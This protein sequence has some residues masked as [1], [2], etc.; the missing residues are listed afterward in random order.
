MFSAAEIPAPL[1]FCLWYLPKHLKQGQVWELEC[2]NTAIS[3][4]ASGWPRSLYQLQPKARILKGFCPQDCLPPFLVEGRYRVPVCHKSFM[5]SGSRS[6]PCPQGTET[7]ADTP[8]A[9]PNL[10][11]LEGSCGWSQLWAG[12]LVT[13]QK[14]A[15]S[16]DLHHNSLKVVSGIFYE[17]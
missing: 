14:P 15:T 7:M 8:L 13:Q 10:C 3:W 5:L 1:H 11:C 17:A 4:E 6:E 9:T 16:I 2:P 12:G